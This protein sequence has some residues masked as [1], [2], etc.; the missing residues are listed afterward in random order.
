M[1]LVTMRKS[2]YQNLDLE[3][4]QAEDGYKIK[5]RSFAGETT[6]S[7]ALP[8]TLAQAKT[9]VMDLENGLAS[10][11]IM[12]EVV[13]AWGGK[14]FEA[15][16]A[17]DLRAICKSNLDLMNA[18]GEGGLRIRLHLQDAVELS[19]LPWEFLYQVA[20]NQ[21]LCLNRQTPLVRYLEIP[22]VISPMAIKLPL[23]ILA[24]ISSPIN[25]PRFDVEHEKDKIQQAL[26]KLTKK[27]LVEIMF[28]ETA[29]ISELQ[30]TLRR[31]EY[32][33]FHFTGHSDFD[34]A[35][36]QGLLAFEN[37]GKTVDYVKAEQLGA[38]LSNNA[39]LRL[40]VLNSCKGVRTALTNPFADTATTLVQQGMP[41]IVAMQFSISD[42]AAAKFASEFY[43]A[44]ANGLP[45]DTAVTEARVGVFSGE[46]NLEWGTP[47]LFMRS[48]NG[49]LFDLPRVKAWKKPCRL[50]LAFYIL[51]T[52]LFGL[53]TFIILA[54]VPKRTILAMDV[55]AR[56]VNF[57]LPPEVRRGQELSLLR[58]GVLAKKISLE[59]FQ[60]IELIVAAF[61]SAQRNTAFANPITITPEPRHGRI[62]FYSALSDISLQEVI[63]DSGSSV[64][65]AHEDTSISFQIRQSSQ[66]PHLTLSLG[67]I[68]RITTQGCRVM[69]GAQYD[70]TP[71]FEK[72]ILVQL[73]AISRALDVQGENGG[74]SVSADTISSTEGEFT[75][76]IPQQRVQDLDFFKDEFVLGGKIMRSTID[77]ISIKRNLLVADSTIKSQQIGDLEIT[78]EPN[79]F[80][81]Y[82]LSGEDNLL[83][84]SV[85]GR[86]KSL[87]IGRGTL[88]SELV[89]KYLSLLAHHPAVSVAMTCVGWLVTVVLPILLQ[90]KLGQKNDAN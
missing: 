75:E 11:T 72:E 73:P 47:A 6:Q 65:L 19:H 66:A 28:L 15:I 3:F 2:D 56:Q 40:A 61:S 58:S 74:L 45:V 53:M 82:D 59:K 68:V 17:H 86:F 16:F 26:G 39:S 90:A 85:Q 81:I 67:E 52:V 10:N 35:A 48:N 87:Q 88:K 89:P 31:A 79:V 9:F 13:K 84:A 38:I 29:T 22:K 69:D 77:R 4:H 78:A 64:S 32:H 51:M 62:S 1:A 55:F 80:A 36:L 70:L 20:T 44:I 5:V 63:C 42:A 83:R 43:A 21:F 49:V 60:T 30:I 18:K 27:G 8:F 71:L 23:R 14:L 33:V 50:T 46:D 7:L 57:T 37:E 76:F 24:V 25:L 54:E 41:A 12:S 34:E